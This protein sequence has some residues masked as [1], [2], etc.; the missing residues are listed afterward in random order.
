MVPDPLLFLECYCA[1]VWM[2]PPKLD[3]YLFLAKST[4]L[5]LFL[6]RTSQS[7]VS[8]LR[9]FIMFSP[10]LASLSFTGFGCGPLLILYVCSLWIWPQCLGIAFICSL[11]VWYCESDHR[12]LAFAYNWS[13]KSERRVNAAQMAADR[14]ITMKLDMNGT[15]T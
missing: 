1:C 7:G 14:W 13:R 5:A 12:E 6:K 4:S 2:L 8:W 11:I 9:C 15:E 10:M 3:M